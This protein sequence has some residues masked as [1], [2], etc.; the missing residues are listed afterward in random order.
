M[1]RKKEY[2]NFILVQ[3]NDCHWYVIPACCETLWNEFCDSD[4]EAYV[5]GDLP[6]FAEEVGGD[7]SLVVFSNYAIK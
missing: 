1:D 7:P 4:E 3:D 6:D 2:K 5:Y